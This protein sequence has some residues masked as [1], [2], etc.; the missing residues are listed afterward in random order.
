MDSQSELPKG[1]KGSNAYFVLIERLVH[2]S[3]RFL[4]VIIEH[5]FEAV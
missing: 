3:A 2:I 5:V 1:V 4:I